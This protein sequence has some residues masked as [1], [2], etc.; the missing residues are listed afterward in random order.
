VSSYVRLLRQDDFRRLWLGATVSSLGDGATWIALS[1]LV[2]ERTESAAHVGALVFAY[3]APVVIGGLVT[4]PILDRFGARPVMLVDS[5]MRGLVMATVPIAG[6]FTTVPLWTLY[7]VAGL[8]GLLKMVPL[9]GVP[10]LVPTLV[11]DRDLDAANAMESLS[12]GL[13]GVVGPLLAGVLVAVIGAPNV[14]ALDAASFFVFALLLARMSARRAVTAAQGA[15]YRLADGVRFVLHNRLMRTTTL[16]FATFNLGNGALLVLLP[17]YA[18]TVLDGGATV[19]AALTSALLVGELVGSFG[20]GMLS[21][22]R[23]LGRSIAVAQAAVGLA[24]LPMLLRPPLA[25]AVALLFLSGLLTSPLTIWAQTLR[26]RVIPPELRGR[27]FSV[28][29]TTM[30]AAE[31]IGGAVGGLAIASLGIGAVL[32][33]I[34]AAF[35]VPGAAGLRAPALASEPGGAR[36]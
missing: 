35:G 3:G 17:V 4:G 20:V 34:A 2:Y 6:A 19:Y 22:R 23:P 7:G 24:F 32:L 25:G 36:V 12:Y 28:L 9:A 14:L 15:G 26:M 8:Y 18:Q 5:V 13:S 10:T 21:W 16:M 11:A 1:W 29:R 30:Q 33:A 27:V 31:P